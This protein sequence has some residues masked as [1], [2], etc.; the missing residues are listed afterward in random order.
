MKQ[1]VFFFLFRMTYE[2]ISY[3]LLKVRKIFVMASELTDT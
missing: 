2:Q 3:R 1:N